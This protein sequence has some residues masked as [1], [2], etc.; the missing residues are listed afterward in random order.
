GTLATW[1]RWNG[2]AWAT[3]SVGEGYPGQ[4]NTPGTVTILNTDDVTLNVNPTNSIG[5]LIL[6]AGNATS[7]ITFSGANS[8]T[9]GDITINSGTGNGDDKEILVNAGSLTCTS[10]TMLVTG[11][12]NRV[13][14]IN[15][16]TGTV[17]V[18]GNITMND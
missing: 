7:S 5:N 2:T 15:I 10:V 4:F 1:Q 11:N 16:T 13:N 6:E 12:D 18:S 9:A 8:L 3:P 17:T 14:R